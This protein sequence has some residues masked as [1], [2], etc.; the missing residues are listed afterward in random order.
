MS[1]FFIIS[2]SITLL[3][4]TLLS[5]TL[6]SFE[7]LSLNFLKFS[8]LLLQLLLLLLET[9][10]LFSLEHKLDKLEDK[11]LFSLSFKISISTFANIY[12]L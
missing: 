8:C 2:K 12:S 4:I 11:E 1:L 7:L 9:L 5:I 6:L 10:V 3:S